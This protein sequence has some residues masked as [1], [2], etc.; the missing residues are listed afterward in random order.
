MRIVE[1]AGEGGAI[2]SALGPDVGNGGAYKWMDV[3]WLQ[4]YELGW[5]AEVAPK[6]TQF[7]VNH[8]LSLIASCALRSSKCMKSFAV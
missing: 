7:R 1:C 8:F 3:S 6:R 5:H 2:P 4:W